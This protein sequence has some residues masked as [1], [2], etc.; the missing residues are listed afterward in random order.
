LYGS[1][2]GS[3]PLKCIKA[4][5]GQEMWSQPGFGLGGVVLVDGMLVVLTETGQLVLVKPDPAAYAEVSRYSAVLGKCWNVPAVSGGHIYAR[6]I[7]EAVC[8]NVAAPPPPP[9]RL[10]TPQPSPTAGLQITIANADSSSIDAGRLPQIEVYTC[11]ILAAGLTNWSK[12]TT[13]LVLT[14]GVVRFDEPFGA[15]TQRY[16]MV[17]EKP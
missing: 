4:A 3:A 5:T 12:L 15:A 6:S 1:T 8:L 10:T 14:N 9:L 17:V 2:S 11:S 13:A 16:F 7:K